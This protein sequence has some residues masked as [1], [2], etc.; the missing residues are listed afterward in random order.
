MK[1]CPQCEFIYEDDQ[2]RCDMDGI[3]LVFD[4]PTPSTTSQKPVTQGKRNSS[5]RS[6]LSVLAVVFG[7]VVFAIGYAALERAITVRSE[8]ASLPPTVAAQPATQEAIAGRPNKVEL[9]PDA[10][11]PTVTAVSNAAHTTRLATREPSRNLTSKA[12]TEPMPD[13]ALGTRG[14]I[15]GS[16]P[17]QNRVDPAQSQPAMIRPSAPPP[18]AKKDSKVASIVKKTG[19]F[20]KKAF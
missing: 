19:R 10:E 9:E 6:L 20:F 5:R 15:V 18:S 12:G 14:V 11:D 4:H 8:P 17:R 1:R 3:D 7:I 16:V 13:N 2:S